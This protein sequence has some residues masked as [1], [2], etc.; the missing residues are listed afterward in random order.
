MKL[1]V[2]ALFLLIFSGCQNNSYYAVE[3][4]ESGKIKKEIKSLNSG[5]PDWSEKEIN[6]IKIGG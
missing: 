4:F 5:V 6:A 2:I 3:Y 1:I